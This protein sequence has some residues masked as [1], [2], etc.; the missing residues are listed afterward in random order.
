MATASTLIP[1]SVAP[2]TDGRAARTRRTS[3]AVVEAYLSLIEEGDLRPSANRIAERAGVSLRT[4]FHHFDDMETLFERVAERQLRRFAPATPPPATGPLDA[5]ID[6]FI[7][8]RTGMLEA[9]T[10][11]RRVA[12]LNEPFAPVLAARLQWSRD[13]ALTEVARVFRAEL[14]GRTRADRSETI[15]ALAAATDWTVW[16]ALRAHQ[17]LS[18]AMATRVMRRTIAALLEQG[19]K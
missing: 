19:T 17:G 12:V 2:R 9:V 14:R 10:P 8:V 5:R 3:D 13:L 16:E 15:A 11:V 1:P 6:A 4:V 18:V 7:A